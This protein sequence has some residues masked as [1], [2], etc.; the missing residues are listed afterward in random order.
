MAPCVYPN[1]GEGG[2]VRSLLFKVNF[3]PA[4]VIASSIAPPSVER[5]VSGYS[6]QRRECASPA[7]TDAVRRLMGET[8]TITVP[9]ERNSLMNWLLGRRAA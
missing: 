6:E 2:R 3:T 8:V 1:E 9:V 5:W 4:S 7:Y